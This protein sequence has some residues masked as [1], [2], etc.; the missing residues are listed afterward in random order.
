MSLEVVVGPMFSGKSSY[1]ISFVRRQN[2]IGRKGIVI[3]PSIDSRYTKSNFL[4]THNK[5]SISCMVWDVNTP[6][7]EF[8]DTTY[9]FYVIEESQF[10]RHLYHFCSELLFKYKKDILVVGLDGCAMQ[11]KFGEILDILPL[12]TCV[13]KLSAYC[14]ICKDG[15][16]AHYS[17]KLEE[18]DQQ[19]DIG[20]AE[21]YVAVC[22]RHLVNDEVLD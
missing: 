1:A 4:F 5:D 22:L 15:T 3:K 12:A 11:K 7:C 13:K 19:I 8:S 14:S 9:D 10:F 18:S 21:K 17:K 20:G 2:A 6:L 16:P